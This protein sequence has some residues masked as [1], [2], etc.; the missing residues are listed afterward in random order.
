MLQVARTM[1]GP[2][3]PAPHDRR[4]GPVDR[5]RRDR[6][7]R[8]A[9]RPRPARRRDRPPRHDPAPVGG[10]RRRRARSAR[11]RRVGAAHTRARRW[12]SSCRTPRR[13]TT[14]CCW[15]WTPAR[16]GG[17]GSRVGP[18]RSHRGGHV[19]A[20]RRRRA[21]AR[22]G[23]AR[24]RA[25][26]GARSSVAGAGA[27]PRHRRGRRGS[28]AVADRLGFDRVAH[29]RDGSAADVARLAR[30]VSGNATG[31]VLGGGGARGFA[32]L[33]VWRALRELG[34]EVDAIGGASIGAPM[35]VMMAL[36]LEPDAL[37]R[38]DR[39]AVPRAARLHR[40]HR[41]AAQ[42]GADRA[43]HH[44]AR[45]A[46][47]TCATLAPVLLRVDEPHPL[48]ASRCTTGRGGDGGA[49]ERGDPR[50][51]A[52]GAVRRRPARR[53]RRAEQPAVRR[54]A[55]HRD[56][57]SAHRGR[58]VAAGRPQA[59]DDYGLSVSGWRACAGR[60][61]QFP[62]IVAVIMRA[63]VAGSVR[64]RDR[65]LAAGAVDCYLDLD[66]A[67]RRAARLRAGRRGRGARLRGG[68]A[69][70]AGVARRH[71]LRGG[72]G[73]RRRRVITAP[74]T[75]AARAAIV[76]EHAEVGDRWRPGA[77]SRRHTSA[78]L[79][80]CRYISWA[81]RRRPSVRRS[82]CRSTTPSRGTGRRS[83]PFGSL[84]SNSVKN[85]LTTST[86]AVPRRRPRDRS[87]RTRCGR[88]RP[89]RRRRRRRAAPPGSTA[90]TS[91]RCPPRR[92]RRCA[93]AA[94]RS[95]PPSAAGGRPRRSCRTT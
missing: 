68:A 14:T 61:S 53:R 86:P 91:R 11:T 81:S 26:R 63:M 89:P 13:G 32:H 92:R 37:E 5:R 80:P 21:P 66:L 95:R 72:R 6:A 23:R 9:R 2:A 67:R 31:L 28:A 20:A 42:G 1:L 56:G 43:Q 83:T 30:L 65:M 70:A 12:R 22:R 74:G 73:D 69:P 41:L 10:R 84:S 82:S 78:T 38:G 90:G 47:S 49:G 16:P 17:R 3:R 77:D 59:Q 40:A 51:A 15:R 29:V 87:W 60:R 85:V 76:D 93:A 46:T 25:R 8:P 44:G 54:D 18:R 24:G 19:G 62:G 7:D 34:I 58:P 71:D 50:R 94:G 39:R 27:P 45:S 35:G 57:G 88:R 48:A 36:Q 64:D 4:P 55:R 75:P 79:P 33:G 52:A